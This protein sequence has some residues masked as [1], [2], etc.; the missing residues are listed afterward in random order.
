MPGLPDLQAQVAL[1]AAGQA[2]LETSLAGHKTR[3]ESALTELAAAS[4]NGASVP[5]LIDL[6]TTLAAEVNT[7]LAALKA[8]SDGE[9]SQTYIDNLLP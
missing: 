7:L 8:W 4:A 6:T 2:A 3:L 9:V 1:L 5:A